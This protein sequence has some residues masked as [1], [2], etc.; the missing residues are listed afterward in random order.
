VSEPE[1]VE[2]AQIVRDIYSLEGEISLLIRRGWDK[3][4]PRGKRIK[5]YLNAELVK[6]KEELEAFDAKS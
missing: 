2:R 4:T 1:S 3:A 5:E 6:A